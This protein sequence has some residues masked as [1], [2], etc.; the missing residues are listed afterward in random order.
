MII[1]ASYRTDIPAFYGPWF[2]NRLR[3]GHCKA[4]NPY[5]GQVGTVSLKREDVDG[6]VFW[7][8]NLRPFGDEL[9]EIRMRGYPFVVQF[10]INGYP[11]DL[12]PSVIAP[13]ASVALL[14]KVSA[15]FGPRVC[16][17]RYDTIILSSLTTAEWHVRNFASLARA[18][19]GATDEVVVS[20][21]QPYRKSVRAMDAAAQARGFAWRDPPQ[22]EK[23]ALAARLA[24]IARRHGMQ[25]SMCAQREY[26]VPGVADA[27][28]V[29]AERLSDV[30]G[31]PFTA[32]RQGHRKDCGCWQSRDIGEYD[33]CPHGCVYC[34]AVNDR[35]KAKRRQQKHDPESEF[36]GGRVS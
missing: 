9:A 5:G 18:L 27:R 11:R 35:A 2:M 6:I 12:E 34:Y 14:R 1:S 28:C 36:L 15:E 4:V 21:M 23:K 13:R 29:D 16:V 20:F 33:T 32:R 3:A 30:A 17:W 26:I 10:G 31:R 24:E 22:D 8:K 25:L 19:S 7:T